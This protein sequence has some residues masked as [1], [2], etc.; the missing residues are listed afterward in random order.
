MLINKIIMSN[1]SQISL[2]L[3]HE[4]Q[5][6]LSVSYLLNYLFSF[7]RTFSIKCNHI[8][9]CHHHPSI[10]TEPLFAVRCETT[11][12]FFFNGWPQL[13]LESPL[14]DRHSICSQTKTTLS[15]SA[16]CRNANQ[17]LSC[18]TWQYN[19]TRTGSTWIQKICN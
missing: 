16:S 3:V 11:Y 15:Y 17:G 7:F 18:T 10:A 4:Q 19:D 5:S 6:P 2:H 12:L 9:C 14:I 8:I 1:N 13:K